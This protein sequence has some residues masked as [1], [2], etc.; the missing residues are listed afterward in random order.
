[1]YRL[2]GR[3]DGI[4]SPDRRARAR[5]TIR[6]KIKNFEDCVKEVVSM[7]ADCKDK[8]DFKPNLSKKQGCEE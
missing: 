7:T 5:A 3:E 6:A 1:M 2:N 4:K 8:D